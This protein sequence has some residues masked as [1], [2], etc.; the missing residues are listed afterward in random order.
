MKHCVEVTDNFMLVCYCCNKYVIHWC[1]NFRGYLMLVLPESNETLVPKTVFF[2]DWLTQEVKDHVKG[3]YYFAAEFDQ[4]S[5][6]YR[7]LHTLVAN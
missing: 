1:V 5:H 7:Q 2:D 4:V 3:T 6:Y